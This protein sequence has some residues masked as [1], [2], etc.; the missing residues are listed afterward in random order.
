M[1][2]NANTLGD[3]IL[4]DFVFVLLNTFLS[5]PVMLK[6]CVLLDNHEKRSFSCMKGKKE[7]AL[8]CQTM[9]ETVARDRAHLA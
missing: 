8:E 2:L 5:L 4:T 6:W 3:R 7:A 1:Y 9:P